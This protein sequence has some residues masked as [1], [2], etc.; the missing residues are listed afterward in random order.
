MGF[1]NFDGRNFLTALYSLMEKSSERIPLGR[2]KRSCIIVAIL[3]AGSS[4]SA[5]YV[6]LNARTHGLAGSHV[7]NMIRGEYVDPGPGGRD[8]VWDFSGMKSS[9]EFSGFTD[10]SVEVDKG[11]RFPHANVALKEGGT[12]FFF[13]QEG[14]KLTALGTMT[15]N[16]QV[17]MRYDEPFIK[18]KYPFAYGDEF[19]GKYKGTYYLSDKRVPLAGSYKVKADGYGKLILPGKAFD[20]VLRVVSSRAYD[21]MFD[22]G[23]QSYEIL[24]YRWYSDG[25]RFPLAVLLVTRST[26]CN[27]EGNYT[28]SAYYT[29]SNHADEAS[30]KTA[31]PGKNEISDGLLGNDGIHVRLYPNPVKDRFTLVYS[32]EEAS[33]VRIELY[34]ITGEKIATLIDRYQESGSY[35]EPFNIEKYALSHGVYHIHGHIGDRTMEVTFIRE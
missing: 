16:G 14:D 4:I 22:N 35:S 9:Q 10:P 13:C 34:D 20:H 12:R 1:V 33:D 25:L 31:G 18:M 17:R 26:V 5:Q 24:T 19:S 27:P 8:L 3:V 29:S 11:Y 2:M 15:T 32:V 30:D 23:P 6:V 7:N 21:V 28:Y